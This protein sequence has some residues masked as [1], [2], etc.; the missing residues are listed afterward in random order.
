MWLTVEYMC[1]YIIHTDKDDDKSTKQYSHP[2]VIFAILITADGF[3]LDKHI[4]VL[5]V[6]KAAISYE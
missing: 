5:D 4:P 2:G 1:A 3:K 6:S